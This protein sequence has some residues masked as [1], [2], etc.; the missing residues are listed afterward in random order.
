MIISDNFLYIR[1]PRTASS[2]IEKVLTKYHDK[3]Y[4]KICKLP[5]SRHKRKSLLLSHVSAKEFKLVNESIWKEKTTFAFVRNP[6][7]RV[8]SYFYYYKLWRKMSFKKFVKKYV[9]GQE[10]LS[11]IYWCDQHFWVTN[12]DG[13]LLVDHIGKFENLKDD[14][15]KI[16]KIINIQTPEL[17]WLKKSKRKKPYMEYYD[18]ET[19][20]VVNKRCKKDFK[21][22][23]Y[24]MR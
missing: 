4:D 18:R 2:S 17:P 3:T 1:I 14:L 16:C 11:T 15:N 23:D 24:K 13:K 8:V 21:L 7:D 20:D 12:K 6:Y 9:S 22:F 10:N 19:I 5:S